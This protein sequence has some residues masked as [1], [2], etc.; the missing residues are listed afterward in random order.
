MG[1]RVLRARGSELD[2]AF[3]FGVVRQL[4]ERPVAEEPALLAGVGEGA[5][6]GLARVDPSEEAREAGLFPALHALYWLV[7]DLAARRPLAIVVDDAHW[8]D[9]ASLRWLVF[10]GE[11]IEELP[12]VLIAATRPAEPGADQELLDALS[13]TARVVGLAPLTAAAS[14]SV[15]RTALGAAGEDA[16]VDACHRAT[17]GNPFLLEALVRELAADGA[18]GAAAEAN[19]ALSFGP[20]GVARAVRR[21]LRALG[22]K[23]IALARAVAVLGASA[24]VSDAAALAG[25]QEPAARAASAPPLLSMLRG[26]LESVSLVADA[27]TVDPAQGAVTLMTL[28]A[29]KGLEFPAVFMLAVEQGILPHERSLSRDKEVEEERRLAFVGMT[30]AREELYLCHAR[31]RDFRGQT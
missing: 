8:A 21:R 18:R 11:R 24:R 30:R 2:R 14:A 27:D 28:H 9:A 13:A 29:A 26:Y 4:L 10:L 1:L 6:A 22:P 7:V 17:G 3:A 12:V 20:E 15:V 19:R 16:F 25:A 5:A 23:A 31:L